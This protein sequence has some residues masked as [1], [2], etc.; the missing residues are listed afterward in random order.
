MANIHSALWL[1]VLAVLCIVQA[2]GSG[3]G[4]DLVLPPVWNFTRGDCSRFRNKTALL[5]YFGVWPEDVPDVP[6]QFCCEYQEDDS[7]PYELAN[8]RY[9]GDNNGVL[10]PLPYYDLEIADK[11]KY[12]WIHWMFWTL[13]VRKNA[14]VI[15]CDMTDLSRLYRHRHRRA[16]AAG[17]LTGAVLGTIMVAFAVIAGTVFHRTILWELLVSDVPHL[18]LLGIVGGS[19]I[20]AIGHSPLRQWRSQIMYNTAV[21][22]SWLTLFALVSGFVRHFI[23]RKEEHERDWMWQKVF[24]QAAAVFV[25][26]AYVCL[27]D[28]PA[29]QA[30][31]SFGGIMLAFLAAVCVWSSG[32]EILVLFKLLIRIFL[33][34]E[35]E[36]L[37][38]ES[39]LRESAQ[40]Q[41]HSLTLSPSPHKRT[42]FF[43][44]RIEG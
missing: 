14:V 36:R 28:D 30:L 13:P 11:L 37:F 15:R 35:E 1:L 3:P 43:E 34:K 32:V 24:G 20:E 5:P 23:K 33:K 9:P 12:Y 19:L 31:D 25:V 4:G 8:Y 22:Y 26:G 27:V 39:A 29:D 38:R 16:L 44:V 18:M 21:V 41:C 40:K 10:E 42:I 17:T 6:F 2:S 7:G